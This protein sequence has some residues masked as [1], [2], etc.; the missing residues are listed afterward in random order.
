MKFTSSIVFFLAAAVSTST[1][2]AASLRGQQQSKTAAASTSTNNAP[3]PTI[4]Q[5][6]ANHKPNGHRKL[7]FINDFEL[8]C[9]D[10]AEDFVIGFAPEKTEIEFK[11]D[12][13]KFKKD[14]DDELVAAEFEVRCDRRRQN[15][16]DKVFEDFAFDDG[17]SVLF[18]E[19]F[20]KFDEGDDEFDVVLE[21][22][23][24]EDE[25][26]EIELVCSAFGS[27]RNLAGKDDDRE[28]RIG[29]VFVNDFELECDDKEE[30]FVIGFA[31]EKTEIEFKVDV[32]KFKKDI[33][34]ELVAAKFR[35]RCDRK[36]Q[37]KLDKVFEDFAFDDGE[38]VFFVEGFEKFDEGDDDFDVVFEN[39]CEEDEELEIELVCGAFGA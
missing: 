20:E 2:A 16:L 36:R 1:T 17:R 10:K 21:N 9:D 38:I 28:Q 7:T 12:V 3:Q 18:V 27:R 26:L 31:P 34:D 33:D 22:P 32:K 4:V 35:V 19:G 37:N 24:E 13:K 23:C 8:E 5:I 30:D 39:P 15:K 6:N 11:V 25:E 29:A 14:I